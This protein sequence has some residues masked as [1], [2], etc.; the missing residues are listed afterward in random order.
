MTAV[1]HAELK[2]L[3]EEATPGPWTYRD[4][5]PNTYGPAFVDAS[6]VQSLAICGDAVGRSDTH[7]FCLQVDADVRMANAAFIAA[8]NPA[9]VLELLSEIEGLKAERDV[10]EVERIGLRAAIFGSHDYDPALRHASFIEM[11]RL[12]EDARKGA[13]SRATEAERQLAAL[14]TQAPDSWRPDRCDVVELINY[15]VTTDIHFDLCGVEGAADAILALR[16]QT[17]ESG[18]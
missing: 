13:L 16:P 11:A 18:K 12:T 3:A 2:R 5:R 10:L 6:D 1:D 17:A 9:V 8:A 7:G 15:Y 14:R 4:M